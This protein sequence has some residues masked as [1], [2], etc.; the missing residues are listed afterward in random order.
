MRN[1]KGLCVLPEQCRRVQNPNSLST[2]NL[3]FRKTFECNAPN[4]EYNEC[5]S[6]CPD[7]CE[8][9]GVPR[10]CTAVCVE[11]CFCK[12]GYVRD[13]K[14]AEKSCILPEQCTNPP[15]CNRERE[16]YNHCGTVCP[17]TCDN[18]Q[19]PPG[20]PKICKSGCFCEEGYV[21][22]EN[23]NCVKP[24][25]CPS[26]RANICRFKNEEITECDCELKCTGLK[27]GSYVFHCS[28]KCVESCVCKKGLARHPVN[29]SCVPIKKCPKIS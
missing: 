8:N 18:Y 3:L 14:S 25:T 24:E 21:R 10:F 23:W 28:K 16:F 6:S 15:V 7:T 20:C 9:F 27:P 4:E 5:G 19:N 12:P 2:D 26:I 11:G 29:G 13:S 1:S 22:D 17:L